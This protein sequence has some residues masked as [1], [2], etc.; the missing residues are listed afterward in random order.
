M[1][2][3]DRIYKINDDEAYAGSRLL[4]SREG[5]IA[6]SSTGAA[7]AAAQQKTKKRW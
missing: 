1:S 3:V 4:A 2:L 6:G 7:F 5:I